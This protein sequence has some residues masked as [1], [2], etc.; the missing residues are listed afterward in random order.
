MGG[1]GGWQMADSRLNGPPGQG[2][3]LRERRSCGDVGLS[4]AGRPPCATAGPVG[5][6]KKN[7]FLIFQTALGGI[8]MFGEKTCS[9]FRLIE[10]YLEVP[11]RPSLLKEP[12]KK[13][14]NI[15]EIELLYVHTRRSLH[16]RTTS[17]I[18]HAFIVFS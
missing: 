8:V 9:N 2:D 13:S 4:P 18:E 15:P 14:S 17:N 7:E 3:Q 16:D 12:L 11:H 1:G 5:W 6:H 10:E